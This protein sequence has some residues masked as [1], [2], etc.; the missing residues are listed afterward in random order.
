MTEAG[1]YPVWHGDLYIS[2]GEK[3]PDGS[4]SARLQVKPF[5][6]FVWGGALLMALERGL[7]PL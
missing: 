4:W 5:I 1:I 6:R 7:M 3:L 2:L